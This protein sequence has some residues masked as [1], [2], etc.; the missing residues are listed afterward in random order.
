V[1]E[2]TGVVVPTEIE[3]VQLAVPSG[4]QL[5]LGQSHFIKT[6]EDI[7]E[8]LV[9]SMPGIKFSVCFCESS[10]KALIRY[11]GTDERANRVALD[12]ATRLSA[13]H[14]FVV[15]LKDSYPINVLNRIKAVEEVVNLY[16]ATA[17]TVTVILAKTED[18][19]GVLG[20]IDGVAAKGVESEGDRQERKELLRKLGYK[21]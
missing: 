4:Y 8:T 2:L 18:G 1:P 17:N 21:R 16:C 12:F 20:V 10:G 3:A 11:D 9:S 7:Y 5:I 13:G 6:V 14:V 15:V 19:R